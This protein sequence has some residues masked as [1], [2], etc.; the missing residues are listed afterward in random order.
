MQLCRPARFYVILAT[1]S[2]IL[3][4]LQNIGS[5][6]LYIGSYSYPYNPLSALGA[7]LL[8]IGIWTFVLTLLCKIS[9]TI[10]WVLVLF[11]YVL[12]FVLIAFVVEESLYQQRGTTQYSIVSCAQCGKNANAFCLQC[13]NIGLVQ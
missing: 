13:Q 5:P 8:Y 4:F 2:T 11:P 3:I 1:V 10:S 7:H 12:I 9:P 6:R